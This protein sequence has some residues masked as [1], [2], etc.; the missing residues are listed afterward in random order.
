MIPTSQIRAVLFD[1][2]GTLGYDH[3]SY[4]EGFAALVAAMGYP[5]DAAAYR[6]ASEEAKA[7]VPE[8]PRDAEAWRH[9]RVAYHRELLRCLGVPDADLDAM[10]ATVAERLRYYTRPACY[11]EA[12]YVLRSLRYAGY[13]V[14]VISNISPA[15]PHVLMELGISQHLAFAVASDTFGV[16]KPD[17]SIFREGLRLAGVPAESAMYVGDGFEPDV[18]GSSAVG[19]RPVLIDRDGIYDGREGMLREREGMLR[20]REGVLRVTNLTQILDWLGIDSWGVE[21]L[22]D[23]VPSR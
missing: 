17:P 22:H 15:L 9:W 16:A 10:V 1:F 5:A 21:T 12:R 13:I 7:A 3:P 4:Q 2:G 6:R 19:M 8:A 20:E 11:P 18:V 23:F 14:G